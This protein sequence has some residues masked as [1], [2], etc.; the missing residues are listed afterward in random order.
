MKYQKFYLFAIALIVSGLFFAGCEDSND[1]VEPDPVKEVKAPTDLM[2]TSLSDSE[3]AIKFEHSV[4]KNE[5]YFLDYYVTLAPGIFE[6]VILDKKTNMHI[7]KDLQKETE[8][9]ITVVARNIDKNESEK[10][11]IRWA[12][13]TRFETNVNDEPIRLYE[14]ASKLGSGLQIFDED[15]LKPKTLTV[16]SKD[17]WNV[18]L[19]TRDAK[20]LLFGSAS[21]IEFGAGTALNPAELGTKLWFANSLNEV[22]DSEALNEGVVFGENIFNLLDPDFT[23]AMNRSIVL[24]LRVKN[25]ND[26]NYAK[27]LIKRDSQ[28]NFL[29]GQ[30]DNRYVECVISYQSGKNLPYAK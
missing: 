5:D 27:I 12:T 26:Y 6:P 29:Q 14:Y 22:Y 1:P 20:Q 11:E 8:Y 28:G 25:G 30:K 7:F 23:D 21:K 15:G 19:D 9:T 4:S 10:I 16:A 2:A 13:A 3:I 17:K 18:A 24:I